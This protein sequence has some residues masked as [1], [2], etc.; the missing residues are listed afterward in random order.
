MAIGALRDRSLQLLNSNR[1]ALGREFTPA[2]PRHYSHA[3]HLWD[4]GYICWVRAEKK[5]PD[6]ARKELEVLLSTQDPETGFIP[7][8][9]FLGRGRGL[10]PEKLIVFGLNAKSSDYSQPPNLAMAALATFQSFLQQR[11]HEE[12]ND[13]LNRNYSSLVAFYRY[14]TER[15]R[16]I[17]ESPLIYLRDPSESGR[18]SDR[19]FDHKK[20]LRVPYERIPKAFDPFMRRANGGL[21]YF[22]ALWIGAKRRL[23]KSDFTVTDVMFNCI[24]SQNLLDM[25][26]IA[27]IVENQND[28]EEFDMR[29]MSVEEEVI[30]AMWDSKDFAFYASDLISGPIKKISITSLFPLILERPMPEQVDKMIEML[31][32]PDLFATAFPVPTQPVNSRDYDPAGKEPRLWRGPV[33]IN[34]NF[35]LVKGL[36]KQ[37]ARFENTFADLSQRARKKA[38]HIATKTKEL[39]EKSGYW[40]FYDPRTGKGLR[41]KD[42]AWSTLADTL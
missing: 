5:D 7:N 19:I 23:G 42:F 32:D 2:A 18:D 14:F 9:T 28:A 25:A 17:I 16:D 3:L 33:W 34:T 27:K 12:A 11:R 6:G 38:E 26:R 37:A 29:A 10:D 30:E 36:E 40:E 1:A 21:D 22:S 35:H 15:Q 24:Y 31:E 4:N 20:P 8:M 13:F 41:I 39:I